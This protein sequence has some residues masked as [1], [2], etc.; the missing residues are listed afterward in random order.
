MG[1]VQYQVGQAKA[2]VSCVQNSKVLYA[3]DEGLR[4]RNVL[5]LVV[6]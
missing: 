6:D 1:S 4:G 5:Q 3:V 2:F